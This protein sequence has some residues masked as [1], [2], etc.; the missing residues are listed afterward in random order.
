MPRPIR[1]FHLS[2]GDVVY[3]HDAVTSPDGK[4][5]WIKHDMVGYVRAV[6]P[7]EIILVEE[8]VVH[9]PGPNPVTERREQSDRPN[10]G[11]ANES[12]SG[13]NRPAD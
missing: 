3:G 11:T 12:G 1:R 5:I 4:T 2:N 13:D 7:A 9:T 10:A 8:D 6:T